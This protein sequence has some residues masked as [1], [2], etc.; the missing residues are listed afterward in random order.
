MPLPARLGD[1]QLTIDLMSL[2]DA[3]GGPQFSGPTPFYHGDKEATQL[4]T[5]LHALSG[6][7]D[8]TWGGGQ[9][10]GVAEQIASDRELAEK[11]QLEEIMGMVDD[12]LAQ[13]DQGGMTKEQQIEMD[14]QL[15]MAMQYGGLNL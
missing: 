13:I 11:L 9:M 10:P 1:P 5:R 15:A 12:H 7:D 6:Y 3:G 14:R 4:Q 2:N 8:P